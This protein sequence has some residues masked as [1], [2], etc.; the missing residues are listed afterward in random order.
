M[1]D[2]AKKLFTVIGFIEVFEQNTTMTQTYKEAYER[3]ET[4]F[5]GF[6]GKPRYASYESFKVIKSRK[7]KK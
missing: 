7:Q 3:T 1:N 6:F 2:R 5:E 4:E